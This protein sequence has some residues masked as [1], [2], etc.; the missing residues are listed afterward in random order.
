MKLS[1]KFLIV[2][3]VILLSI[4]CRSFS[5]IW[6]DSIAQ[7]R[8]KKII[9]NLSVGFIADVAYLA[10][11][12]GQG[13]SRVDAKFYICN[14]FDLSGVLT[15]T[16][17]RAATKLLVDW[18]PSG[19][20]LS[21]GGFNVATSSDVR[22]FSFDGS[23]LSEIPAAT[24]DHGAVIKSV[25]WSN[26]DT[27]LAIA[28][29][30]G[31]GGAEVRVLSFDGSTLSEIATATFTD[32]SSIKSISW[33]HDGN[34]LAVG[35]GNSEVFVLSFDGSYLLK[36]PTATFDYENEIFSVDWAFSCTCIAVGGENP[37]GGVEVKT[38]NFNGSTLSEV[39]TVT[40]DQDYLDSIENVLWIA[41]DDYLVIGGHRQAGGYEISLLHFD[42]NELT[43][44]S[45]Q[46]I[47]PDL[48]Y[49]SDSIYTGTSAMSWSSDG[50]DL[51]ISS[52]SQVDKIA[53]L[54]FDGTTWLLLSNLYLDYDNAILSMGW[55]SN[56]QHMAVGGK[57]GTGGYEVRIFY[58][59]C[60]REEY[61]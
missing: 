10:S 34:Y 42:G 54:R 35:T 56:N 27:Y 52:A 9:K 45:L 44:Y 60:A 57:N 30:A 50:S 38:L 12:D 14:D 61:D 24:F 31:T 19:T 17:D 53:S 15:S 28:G 46:E 25:A 16:F 47:V 32:G 5:K 18:S 49:S 39:S 55:S 59:E 1:K 33:L 3:G 6:I 41:N 29:Q 23:L 4:F 11:G 26:D 20:Y 21:V 58:L 7:D 37:T 2:S 13:K 22:V 8:A 43:I 36:I 51:E 48:N 40:F